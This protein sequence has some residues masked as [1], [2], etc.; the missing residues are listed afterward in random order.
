MLFGGRRKYLINKDLQARFIMRFVAVATVWATVTVAL[1]AFLAG[2][3]LDDLRYSSHIDLQTTSDLLLPITIKVQIISLLIFAALLA[4]TIR[5]L[6]RKFSPPLAALKRGIQIIADGDLSNKITL[7][8]DDEFHGLA[9][10]LD[11]MRGSLQERF[12]RI[13]E[14]RQAIAAAAAELDM[15]IIGGKPTLSQVG[16]LKAAV[17]GMR[18]NVKAFNYQ[19]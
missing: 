13:K 8:K 7:R 10:E 3:K 14:Q 9:A 6:W 11:E 5:A 17:E 12:I 1:F 16:A 19:N 15:A 4:Y 2:K 18:A